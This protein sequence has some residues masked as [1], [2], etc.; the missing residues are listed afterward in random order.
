Y[1]TL[2]EK[3]LNKEIKN[4][5]VITQEK[6]LAYSQRDKMII[7]M[8]GDLKNRNIVLRKDDYDNYENNFPLITTFVKSLFT[9]NTI[10]FIGYSLNDVNVKLIMKWIKEILKDDFRKVYLADLS[11]VNFQNKYIDPKDKIVNRILV[12]DLETNK[13]YLSTI[14]EAEEDKGTLLVN[15]LKSISDKC[16]ESDL[17]LRGK[18]FKKLNYI[19]NSQIKKILKEDNDNIDVQFIHYENYDYTSYLTKKISIRNYNNSKIKYDISYLLKS[20][21]EAIKEITDKKINY[22]ELIEFKETCITKEELEQKHNLINCLLEF[23]TTYNFKELNK[24]I[25]NQKP[26]NELLVAYCYYIQ[27]Q[28]SK[29]KKILKEFSDKASDPELIL[30]GLFNLNLIE[31]IEK[32]YGILDKEYN[33]DLE[34]IYLDYF[35]S[36]NTDLYDEIFKNSLVMSYYEDFSN[37]LF[38]IKEKKNSSQYPYSQLELAQIKIRDFLNYVFLNG[39]IADSYFIPHY[40]SKTKDIYRNY[41]DIILYAYKNDVNY[42]SGS[43]KKNKLMQFSYIDLYIMI[44]IDFKQLTTLFSEHKI[45][46]ITV[47][48]TNIN[49]LITSFGH[50]INFFKESKYKQKNKDIIDKFLLVI[51]KIDLNKTNIK[52]VMEFLINEEIIKFYSSD[53][54]NLIISIIDKN[55][56]DIDDKTIKSIIRNFLLIKNAHFIYVDNF[57]IEYLTEAYI[58]KSDKALNITTEIEESGYFNEID[59]YFSQ[60]QEEVEKTPENIGEELQ[61]IGDK[62]ANSSNLERILINVLYLSRISNRK[63]KEKVIKICENYLDNN[64]SINIYYLMLAFELIDTNKEYE[65]KIIYKIK[66]FEKEKGLLNK[67]M[68]IEYVIYLNLKNYTSIEFKKIL[69]KVDNDD[70]KQFLNKNNYYNIY[71]YS[72]NVDKFDFKRFKVEDLKI[73]SDIEIKKLLEKKFKSTY[74]FKTYIS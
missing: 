39:Y 37:L 52:K 69:D 67:N 47:N 10:L 8:H 33:I 32:R 68:F 11:R 61:A 48:G 40:I 25:K 15:F 74:W 17:L 13:K 18:L 65:N 43:N 70:L 14:A 27:D 16:K 46:E 22:K 41:I 53:T 30:W 59:R 4:Y 19:L 36:S 71:S 54:Y 2:I 9:T 12:R 26:E 34:E 64:F 5:D 23:V 50:F 20:N 57:V 58:K 6:D 44:Q 7:K 56:D 31:Q 72:L 66:E 28:F 63:F 38:K 60:L 42:S 1:D 24:V 21:V 3:K 49:T 55:L 45:K 29:S 51:S 35:N 62:L 73:L